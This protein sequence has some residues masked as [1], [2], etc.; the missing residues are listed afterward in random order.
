M[1]VTCLKKTSPLKLKSI[2]SVRA[3]CH[4]FGGAVYVGAVLL[5]VTSVPAQ[6]L[7]EADE[8]SGNIY[9]F[10]ANGVQST[11]ASGLSFPT[12]LAFDRAGDLFVA[13][14]GGTGVDAGNITE[15][16]P[17][18][19]QSTFASG[20]DGPEGLAFDS[21]G[22][23]FVA[24]E[25]SGEITEITPEGTKSTFASGLQHA[26]GL[27]F[28]S[29]GNLFVSVY[30]NSL[31][32]KGG[33]I[34]YGA[35]IEITPGGAKGTVASLGTNAGGGL[36]FNS[37]GDLVVAIDSASGSVTEYTPAGAQTTIVSGLDY[38]RSL[39]FNSAGDLFVAN[40]GDNNIIEI[41]QGG[42]QSMFASGLDYPDGLAF[43]PV[44]EPS[45]LGLLAVGATA[46]LARRRSADAKLS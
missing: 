15:I 41:T 10:A 2:F 44:P 23:L 42:A 7:F 5:L 27:A 39:V 38:P 25:G 8:D 35:I 20:L 34:G 26:T 1:R 22:N 28:N 19:A 17:A 37:F 6:N 13:C 45:A 29:A 18:G 21:S 33:P 4:S 3:G 11:F 32:L 12:G 36:A 30:T 31:P 43:Q 24:D 14:L 16:T 40:S 46:L 9:E